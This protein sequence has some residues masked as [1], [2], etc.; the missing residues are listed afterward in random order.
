MEEYGE[1]GIRKCTALVEAGA[2]KDDVFSDEL[3]LFVG[4]RGFLLQETS[5]EF[6][7]CFER[8][9]L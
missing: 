2:I 7:R 3:I 4:V 9:D 1:Y 8:I 5:G 6:L